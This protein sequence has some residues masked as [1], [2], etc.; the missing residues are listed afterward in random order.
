MFYVRA[1]YK[2]D[3]KEDINI[4]IKAGRE[5]DFPAAYTAVLAHEDFDEIGRESAHDQEKENHSKY[6]NYRNY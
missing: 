4:M 2:Q 5:D 3:L 6:D 1:Q